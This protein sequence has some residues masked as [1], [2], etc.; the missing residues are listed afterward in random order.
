LCKKKLL[1]WL[2]KTKS[3]LS[4]ISYSSFSSIISPISF[5]ILLKFYN[6]LNKLDLVDLDPEFVE[7]YDVT[8]RMPMTT[9]SYKIYGDI[10]S[11]WILYLMNKDQIQNPPF[12]VDGGVRL[13]YI[14]LEYRVLLYNDI[15]KNTILNGRHF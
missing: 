6:I 13:K 2:K 8:T 4:I 3:A 5:A 15:T 10:K 14:K 1:N 9:L 12:W 7:F 11:W